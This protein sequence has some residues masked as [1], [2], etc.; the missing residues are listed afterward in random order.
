MDPLL[1]AQ[2][3]NLALMVLHARTSILDAPVAPGASLASSTSTL[4]LYGLPFSEGF[5]ALRAKVARFIDEEVAPLELLFEHQH[6][7]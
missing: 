5:S 7:E 1:V 3:A 4:S 6:K 2:V